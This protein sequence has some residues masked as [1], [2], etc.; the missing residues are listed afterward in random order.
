[1]ART[2]TIDETRLLPFAKWLMENVNRHGWSI[3]R[4]ADQVDVNVSQLHKII[5]SY[6]PQYTQYQ[7]LGYE[8]TMAIGKL[9]GDV[10]GALKSADYPASHVRETES[11]EYYAATIE[12]LM[13]EMG[14]HADDLTQEGHVR[15][16]QSFDALIIGMVEQERQKK[17]K[18]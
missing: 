10:E 12:T 15:L 4:V 3:Q 7:R 9:F 13:Q 6:L 2:S 1:M 5:K 8:K 18:T 16:R 17:I 11:H 14:Y